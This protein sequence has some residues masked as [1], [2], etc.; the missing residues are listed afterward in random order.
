MSAVA[1]YTS[2]VAT[3]PL[4]RLCPP[5]QLSGS[6]VSYRITRSIVLAAYIER[7]H[8]GWNADIVD[9]I[10]SYAIEYILVGTPWNGSVAGGIGVV[11][12]FRDDSDG[13]DDTSRGNDDSATADALSLSSNIPPLPAPSSYRVLCMAPL[14]DGTLAAATADGSI[15]IWPTLEHHIR[16]F[17]R[18]VAE[19]AE[20]E[21]HALHTN[22]ASSSAA[23]AASS[24]S[25]VALPAAHNSTS[26]LRILRGHRDAVH[27]LEVMRADL[28]ASG[29]AD[30]T[31]RIWQISSGKCIRILSGHT[32][33]V[34]RLCAMPPPTMQMAHTSTSTTAAAATSLFDPYSVELVSSS[35]FDGVRWW[36]VS[37]GRSV[38]F[39]PT[40]GTS[41]HRILHLLD[42]RLLTLSH[43]GT[44]PGSPVFL[45]TWRIESVT[46]DN[47]MDGIPTMQHSERYSPSYCEPETGY[48]HP[49][50]DRALTIGE[51]RITR[52]PN[53]NLSDTRRGGQSQYDSDTDHSVH[54]KVGM[55]FIELLHNGLAAIGG[56]AS[57]SIEIWNLDPNVMQCISTLTGHTAAIRVLRSL[58]TNGYFISCSLDRTIRVWE[59]T[60]DRE[61]SSSSE[62]TSSTTSYTCIR[63]H[64]FRD[65]IL[66]AAILPEVLGRIDIP[67]RGSKVKSEDV[68]AA[69]DIASAVVSAAAA[70]FDST[71]ASVAIGSASLGDSTSSLP[72]VASA[73]P[74]HHASH[75]PLPPYP[76]GFRPAT[77]HD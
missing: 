68:N 38:F 24:P 51:Q 4:L 72:V 5:S 62:S 63:R 30:A 64:V 12:L 43:T 66:E 8:S 46:A 7:A 1:T 47:C 74:N 75:H 3:T 23:V 49:G 6:G 42:G 56:H 21:T 29:S 36:N 22:T 77:K 19:A 9:I 52:L 20:A 17:D 45:E 15:A 61:S 44:N 65:H 10:L 59:W 2:A 11:E 58:P 31:I 13:D 76:P 50:Y 57:G 71:T 70:A 33:A 28:L 34:R 39:Q 60:K 26:P 27:V 37:T 73:H 41:I 25:T 32:Y 35:H 53:P 18:A 40:L 16:T 55:H 14:P 69:A 54:L 48:P 67:G